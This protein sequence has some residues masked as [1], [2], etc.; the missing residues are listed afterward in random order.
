MRICIPIT[1]NT[2]A[3][4]LKDIG[5][6]QSQGADFI[7]LRIDLLHDLSHE[8][9]EKLIKFCKTPTI[10]TARSKEEGGN[11]E[12]DSAAYLQ[13]AIDLNVAFVDIEFRKI[14]KLDLKNTKTIYSYHN[15]K[16]TPDLEE[17]Q[18]IYNKMM[19]AGADIG[20]LACYANS[21]ND[22]EKIYK[23]ISSA[24]RDHII[25]IAMGAIGS[26][27]RKKG[28]E[29]GSYLTFAS[30]TTDKS[31]APGQFTINELRKK[32]IALIGGRGSG[33][34]RA[35]LELALALKKPLYC[36]DKMISE[37]Y[38]GTIP[39][40]IA[41]KGWSYFRDLEYEILKEIC[42]LKAGIIDCG[43]GVVCEQ[44]SNNKQ[45]FSHRKAKLLKTYCKTIWVK[46]SL[47]TQLS[48]IKDDDKRPSLTGEKSTHD[49]LKQIMDLRTPW[50]KE[51]AEHEICTDH[52]DCQYIAKKIVKLLA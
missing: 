24:P 33:K 32:H 29:L 48:R 8:N 25:A 41:E 15:F 44:D 28:P 22:N 34:S 50:Y 37:K 45:S 17:L 12:G 9:L 47:K 27:T 42:D 16:E 20:K 1:A 6:A 35:A 18:N 23:L 43:G 38:G 19:K 11:W 30:L 36:M 14:P 39:Q 4:A 46:A 51:L 49:E 21:T 31:S 13:Q 26:E 40:I 10:V 7:E 52:E 5:E 2:T 3:A